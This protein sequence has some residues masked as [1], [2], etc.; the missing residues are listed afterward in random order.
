MNR[1]I[2]SCFMKNEYLKNTPIEMIDL[3]SNENIV[4]LNKLYLGINVT[5]AILPIKDEHET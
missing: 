1:A 3:D 2:L 4:P 5:K